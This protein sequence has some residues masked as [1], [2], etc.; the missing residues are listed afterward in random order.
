MLPYHLQYVISSLFVLI[1][2]L[3]LLLSLDL[4][5]NEPF[6]ALVVENGA[7][8]LLGPGLSKILEGLSCLSG[9]S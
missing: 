1:R 5:L 6:I 3:L 9:Q 8:S 7:N 4:L 2:L